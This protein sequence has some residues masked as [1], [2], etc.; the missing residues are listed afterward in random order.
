METELLHRQDLSLGGFAGLR[1]YRLVM[2]PNVFGSRVNPG[3]WPGIGNFVYL[4]DAWFNPKGDTRMHSHREVDV[5][6]VM[7]E[8]R[9]AHEGS[10]EHGQ[11]LKALDVQVQRAGGEG[12]SH[13]EVNPDDT[14]N[15][16]LQL[17]V[18]PD[19][20]GQ[21]AGY[22]LYHLEKGA[23]T[24]VYGGSPEQTERFDNGTIIQAGLLNPGQTVRFDHPFV[25]Y[26]ATGAGAVNGL[27]VQAGDLIRGGA[28]E[29]AAQTPALLVAAH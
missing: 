2:D 5:I 7:V 21:P 23:F 26:L 19:K 10:L 18:L 8:G 20:P 12:F 3:T 25:A 9:I 15:R 24:Q 16:M 28:F 6:S 29:F 13:N 11:E 4:A 1:E 27:E 22:K 17:W 14:P